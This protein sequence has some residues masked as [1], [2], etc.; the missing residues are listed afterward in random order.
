M[1]N[2]L[3]S[4]SSEQVGSSIINITPKKAI[5]ELSL[6]VDNEF[7]RLL[8]S[9]VALDYLA[10]KCIPYAAEVMKEFIC[11]YIDEKAKMQLNVVNNIIK[12]SKAMAQERNRR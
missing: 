5:T 6:A 7:A 11:S 9:D 12:K 10:E 4:P 3:W 1:L 2:R 8:S